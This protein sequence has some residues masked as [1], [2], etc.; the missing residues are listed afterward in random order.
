MAKKIYQ[1]GF[2]KVTG[3]Q[4][5]NT[6]SIILIV[7]YLDLNPESITFPKEAIPKI[8]EFLKGLKRNE[9]K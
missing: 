7:E 2:G 5:V 6:D 8:E 4:D 3:W 9:V 1:D